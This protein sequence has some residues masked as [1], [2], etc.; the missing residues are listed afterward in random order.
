VSEDTGLWISLAIRSVVLLVALFIG[1][2]AIPRART[3][4]EHYRLALFAVM[5]LVGVAALWFGTAA[6]LWPDLIAFARAVGVVAAGALLIGLLLLA[7]SYLT[8]EL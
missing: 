7:W 5:V 1:L 3:T 6:R 4:E 2:R 8:G